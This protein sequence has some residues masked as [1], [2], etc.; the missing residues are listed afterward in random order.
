MANL[1]LHSHLLIYIN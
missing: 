1:S